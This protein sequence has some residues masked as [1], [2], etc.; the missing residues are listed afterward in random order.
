MAQNSFKSYHGLLQAL[1]RQKVMNPGIVATTLLEVFIHMNG[2]MKASFI[3]GKGLCEPGKFT[4]WRENLIKKG[5][6]SYTIGAYSRHQPG[7]KLIKYIN[8]EKSFS[9]ELASI[10]DVQNLVSKAREEMAT[11]EELAQVKERVSLLEEAV[12]NMIEE[13]DPPVTEEKIQR[14]LK[15]VKAK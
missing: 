8:K 15:I 4:E 7:P 5:W 10:P 11:K 9:C 13:F 14:R 3:Q 2:D 1:H 6:L 12:K